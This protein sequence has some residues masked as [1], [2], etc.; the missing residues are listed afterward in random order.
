MEMESAE[1]VPGSQPRQLRSLGR[2]TLY[3]GAVEGVMDN[4]EWSTEHGNI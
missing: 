4:E 3:W 2:L 1:D